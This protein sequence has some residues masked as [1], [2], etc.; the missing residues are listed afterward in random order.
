V[1]LVIQRVNDDREWQNALAAVKRKGGQWE[2]PARMLVD[3]ELFRCEAPMRL[4]VKASRQGVVAHS[5]IRDLGT[6]EYAARIAGLSNTVVRPGLRRHGIYSA[7]IYLRNV[8]LDRSDFQFVAA[9]VKKGHEQRYMQQYPGFTRVKKE[10]E[11]GAA[12]L[13]RPIG[14]R[15]IDEAVWGVVKH[16]ETKVKKW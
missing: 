5:E 2:G 1:N 16:L 6:A 3:L 9:R 8:L 13:L 4:V 14:P 11:F 12:W 15:S 7:I 10:D